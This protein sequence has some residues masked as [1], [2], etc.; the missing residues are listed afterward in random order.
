MKFLSLALLIFVPT[1]MAQ[2]TA[3]PIQPLQLAKTGFSITG[4]PDSLTVSVDDSIRGTTPLTLFGM[5]P[6]EHSIVLTKK[7]FYGKKI[8]A[9]A[10]LDSVVSVSGELR[11]PASLTIISQPDSALIFVNRKKIDKTPFTIS[12]LRP[13]TYAVML[14]KAGYA[15][16][17]TTISLES[18]ISDTLRVTLVSTVPVAGTPVAVLDSTVGTK[19]EGAKPV[20]AKDETSASK[21]R[22]FTIIGSVVFTGFL[23]ILFASEFGSND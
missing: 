20:I 3:I 10:I 12:P 6:G 13:E 7:G 2:E 11:A 8:S 18:G 19:S 9:T 21:K 1:L 4:T 15:Q 5:T 16:V 17:D 23:A 22:L 14:L